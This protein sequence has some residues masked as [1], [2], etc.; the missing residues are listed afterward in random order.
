MAERAGLLGRSTR[1]RFSSLRSIAWSSSLETKSTLNKT[2]FVFLRFFNSNP[3][4]FIKQTFR[5]QCCSLQQGIPQQMEWCSTSY[6]MTAVWAKVGLVRCRHTDGM[7]NALEPSMYKLL[8][9]LYKMV[10]CCWRCEPAHILT[11]TRC[12]SI[13]S[14]YLS[15]VVSYMLY[16]PAEK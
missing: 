11:F 7:H 5:L 6:C 9:S 16:S 14:L 12:P 4:V 13:A 1:I 8:S 2:H 3:A 15:T 10:P